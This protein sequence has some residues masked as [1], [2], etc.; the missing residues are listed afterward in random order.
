MSLSLLILTLKSLS[1]FAAHEKDTW[2][3]LLKHGWLSNAGSNLDAGLT[4][5]A[6]Q[7]G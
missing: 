5:A 1:G 7:V 4:S 2:L 3:D 6:A